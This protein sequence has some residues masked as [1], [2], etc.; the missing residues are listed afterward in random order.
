[1]VIGVGKLQM[2]EVLNT[3]EIVNEIL[4]IIVEPYLKT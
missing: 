4:K 3:K 1:M 2:I